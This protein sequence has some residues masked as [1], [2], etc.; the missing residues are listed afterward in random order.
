MYEN[1]YF[2]YNVGTIVFLQTYYKSKYNSISTNYSFDVVHWSI[3]FL[4]KIIDYDNKIKFYLEI[5]YF[6]NNVNKFL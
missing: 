1:L 2:P 5:K 6:S 3:V 4:R